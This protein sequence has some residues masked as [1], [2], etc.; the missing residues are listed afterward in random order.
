[1]WRTCLR[2]QEKVVYRKK[3][4]CPIC[5]NYCLKIIHDTAF[6][7]QNNCNVQNLKID[8]IITENNFQGYY[9]SQDIKN[10]FSES[11]FDILNSEFKKITDDELLYTMP[12]EQKISIENL[13]NQISLVE[14]KM[15]DS[16]VEF[17]NKNK[18]QDVWDVSPVGYIIELIHDI[19]FFLD[20]CSKDIIFFYYAMGL[21]EI[22]HETLDKGE[23]FYSTIFF[24]DNAV[25]HILFS[26]ERIY[27]LLAIFYDYEFDKNLSENRTH[28]IKKFLKNKDEFKNSKIKQILESIHGNQKYNYI[29]ETREHNTHNL[30]SMN[31]KIR[32]DIDGNP[33]NRYKY[34]KD[35]DEVSKEM[36]LP[37]IESIIYC[38]EKYH[39]ILFE[40]MLFDFDQL[41]NRKIPML[42][43]FEENLLIRNTNTKP[44]TIDFMQNIEK[45]KENLFFCIFICQNDLLFDAFFRINEIS[46][47][48]RDVYCI[49]MDKPFYDYWQKQG[50][51]YITFIDP[52]YLLYSSILRLYSCYDKVAKDIA[53]KTGK[54]TNVKHF[55]DFKK[56]TS[57]KNKI[58]QEILKISTSENYKLLCNIR[59]DSFHN[60][61]AGCLA[62]EKGIHHF[63]DIMIQV[64]FE[65][66]LMLLELLKLLLPENEVTDKQNLLCPCGRR[67]K[68]NDCCG[69]R[70]GVF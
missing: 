29:K 61:S 10:N 14:E 27:V 45:E 55:E 69:I 4:K 22:Q 36:L 66:M 11:S 33:D 41:K 37:K 56:Y 9:T 54:Y 13:F 16:A 28:K 57:E 25:N 24:F 42:N 15:A 30:S 60:L 18:L 62:G 58:D 44:Y 26:E 8:T 67:K 39:T 1:M 21:Y 48:M 38:L 59:N 52:Q 63:N 2:K 40:L 23:T 32:D 70:Y 43:K 34:D 53:T 46:K 19:H 49:I 35:T 65:N 7:C 17:L 3:Y 68:Y 51:T 47:C 6:E 20:I 5:N 12:Q 50:V 64:V 31:K